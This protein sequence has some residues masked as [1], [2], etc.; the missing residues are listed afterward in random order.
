MRILK[1]KADQR[2]WLSS[3][4]CLENPVCKKNHV[5]LSMCKYTHVQMCKVLHT[6]PPNL[7]PVRKLTF[8]W[9]QKLL[10]LRPTSLWCRFQVSIPFVS[11]GTS[12][13]GI[14]WFI[15]LCSTTPWG[16]CDSCVIWVIQWII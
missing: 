11:W 5:Y 13:S 9:L 8:R 3:P 6:S 7:G 4:I 15:G 14:T 2:N 10:V 16:K 12:N 1:A